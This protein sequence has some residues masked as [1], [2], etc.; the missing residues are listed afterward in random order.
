VKLELFPVFFKENPKMNHKIIKQQKRNQICFFNTTFDIY[1][2]F[3]YQVYKEIAFE[4]LV[5]HGYPCLEDTMYPRSLNN[6]NKI[7]MGDPTVS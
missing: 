2:I 5:Y 3:W 1:I 6:T 4:V 7:F